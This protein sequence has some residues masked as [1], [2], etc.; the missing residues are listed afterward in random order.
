MLDTNE[1]AGTQSAPHVPAFDGDPILAMLTSMA[2]F[3]GVELDITLFVGGVV[4]SGV[5]IG[6][7]EYM[8]AY[9]RQFNATL[10][11]ALSEEDQRSTIEFAEG[12]ARDVYAKDAT[13][14]Q[15][16]QIRTS[17]KT[18]F[19]HLKDARFVTDGAGMIFLGE[20]GQ[21]F[22]RGRLDKVDGFTL[23]ALSAEQTDQ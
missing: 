7:A 11:D 19:I 22:W 3:S 12:I 9:A 13:P 20:E 8:E 16:T 15:K 5:L 10:G 21:G 1:A 4:I 17:N 6:G 14:E 2:N 23:G 18:M